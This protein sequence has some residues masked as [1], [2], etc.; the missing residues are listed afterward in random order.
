M[1]LM[2]EKNSFDVLR[3][4]ENTDFISQLREVAERDE[5]PLR[6]VRVLLDEA[7]KRIEDMDERISIMTE[8][9]C[10]EDYCEI[11]GE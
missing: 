2:G 6:M 7:A 10:G 9:K 5:M 4:L 11:E 3:N 8:P 1:R